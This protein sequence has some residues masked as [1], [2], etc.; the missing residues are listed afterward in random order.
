MH[1]QSFQ[2]L[3]PIQGLAWRVRPLGYIVCFVACLGLA[4]C[5]STSHRRPV[6][7]EP[8]PDTTAEATVT[9]D[10]GS[11]TREEALPEAPTDAGST[12][13]TL[14]ADGSSLDGRRQMTVLHIND[15]YRIG[16]VDEGQ[17]GGLARVRALRESLEEDA[18]DLLFTHAG[19]LLFPSLLSRQFQGAQMIDVLN[20]MDGDRHSFDERMF[21][22]FGNHEFDKKK[23][24]D[25]AMLDLRVE[26]SAFYWLGTNIRFQQNDGSKQGVEAW[27]LIDS[28]LVESGGIKVGIFGLS[29]DMVHPAYVQSFDDPTT[30]ARR[31]VA[32][33]R[34]QGAEVVIALTHLT[35]TEDVAV[36]EALGN[37]GPDLVLGGHE[38]NRQR[39]RVGDRWILKADA[40]ARTA[41]VV[42]VG[43]DDHGTVD[44]SF[45]FP[46]L[47]ASSDKD[48]MVQG[49]VD[50]WVKVHDQEFCFENL[51]LPPG[52]LDDVFG[53][54]DV[55][56]LGEELSIRRYETNLGNW[57]VDRAL[58]H[59]AD[60][61]AQVAFI[62]SGSF[63][64][65][66]DIPA[67]TDIT[68]R[69][70]EETFQYPSFL[71][72][73]R[74]TGA[75]LQQA[76][77]HSVEN[78]TGEGKWMQVS[79]FAFRHNPDTGTADRLTLL[80]PE[81]PRPIHPDEELLLI[82]GDY[83][84]TPA[85]G[86]DGYT[87]LTADMVIPDDDPPSLKD[88]VVAEMRAVGRDGIAPRVEGR[89]CNTQ[90]AG[91]CLAVPPTSP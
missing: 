33:L 15:V 75:V 71:R 54:T 13:A 31:Q 86:Q 85:T 7:H 41:L 48:E 89:I 62:N 77:E 83:L 80:T 6:V 8:A 40:E 12:S 61:G 43:V 29:T 76:I 46:E 51:E 49:V 17:D 90:E 79:G 78:W 68:R 1:R 35:M 36:L 82:T 60:E 39:R 57:I 9:G 37:Q 69:H 64:I 67:D 32:Q 55:R 65:N 88:L 81:G 74:I 25:A 21:A 22:V 52:C 11:A 4:G 19:D 3:L 5:H 42:E 56:L 18:P 50:Q 23:S 45:E 26:E 30:V 63:R 20:L 27:N 16:G 34:K 87:M 59:F 2:E 70:V 66:Q 91:P 73:L 53:R 84:A 10:V 24:K 72:R 38:H 58:E 47:D 14:P 28:R 44:V